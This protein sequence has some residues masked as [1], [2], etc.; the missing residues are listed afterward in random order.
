MKVPSFQ[1]I[2]TPYDPSFYG[3]FGA[4]FFANMGGGGGQNYFRGGFQQRGFLQSSSVTPQET[5][6]PKE[7]GPS[8]TFGTQSATAKEG[9]HF[10]KKPLLKTPCSWFLILVQFYFRCRVHLRK[11]NCTFTKAASIPA[12]RQSANAGPRL[13]D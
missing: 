8:S 10:C 9:T 7:I 12:R 4:I 3:Y 6:I 2:C 13:L 5:K 1:G 11:E